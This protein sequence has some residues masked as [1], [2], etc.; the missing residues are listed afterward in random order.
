MTAA[1]PASS[2]VKEDVK[3]PAKTESKV[4]STKSADAPLKDVMYTGQASL[5]KIE[6]ADW[7]QLGIEHEGVEWNLQNNFRV[8][9]EDLTDGARK[10][11]LKKD[12][13]FSLVDA[14]V[15]EEDDDDE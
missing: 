13:R 5:R 14:L 3:A 12:G 11:L 6:A 4:E 7:L 1:T 10:Y 8:P 9:A 15:D 2:D